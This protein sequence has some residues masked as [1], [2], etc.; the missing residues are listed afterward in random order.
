MTKT[1]TPARLILPGR[2]LQRELDA[3][4][5]TQKDL[6]EIT[7]RPPQTINE[8]IQGTKQI[9]P[10]TARE[11]SAAFGTSAEFWTNLESNYRI[12]L[13]KK[14]HKE[15]QI[16]RKSRLYTLA[17]IS[18]L[19]KRQWIESTESLDELEQSVCKFLGITSPQE[20]PQFNV[21][22]RHSQI[23]SPEYN[24]QIAWCK[25]VEQIVSKQKLEAFQL[26]KLK[27]SIAYILT[28]SEKE[29][30]VAYIP[31]I[32]LDLGV[33]FAIVPHLNKTYLDGAVFYLENHPVVAL[34]LRHNRIDS[35]W[36]TLMHELGHIV[37]G[38]Q[39]VYLDNL[40]E[41]EENPEEE[42]ANQLASNWL[43]DKREFNSFAIRTKTRFSKSAIA[44]F[45]RT[46]NRHPG[47]VLG[48][49]Q[50]HNLVPY[51]N[52]RSLLVKVKPFLFDWIDE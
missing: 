24:S 31:Q 3:R 32:L 19:I 37:A 8:I 1:L 22:F 35:F 5:W 44:N 38:H 27:E 17:P 18:E 48:C 36:F 50:H 42:E 45:A 7:N 47:I 29:E 9:T 43:I 41:L 15:E 12:H 6:A 51:R 52:L 26:D 39:G 34:T 21:S 13:A 4:N 25:R 20:M 28:H 46:Q 40:D 2:I 10:E 23:L 30:N 49:L 11:F 16:E 14:K 33:H